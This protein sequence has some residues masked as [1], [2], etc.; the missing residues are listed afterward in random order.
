MRVKINIIK[1]L[2]M[3]RAQLFCVF[4]IIVSSLIGC[5]GDDFVDDEIDPVI[6]ISNPIAQIE[7]GTTHQFEYNYFNNIGQKENITDAVW[8]SSDETKLSIDPSGLASAIEEG[9]CMIKIER[10]GTSGL[11]MD[12]IEVEVI[13]M[14]VDDPDETKSGTIQT[15]SSYVLT[16]D[17]T[18]IKEEDNLK[19]SFADNYEA[20]T[21][22]PG[23]YVYLSNNPSTIAGAF[24]IGAVTVFSGIHDY[25]VPNVGIND[26]QYLL[27]FCKPFNVKVGDGKIN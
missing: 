12:A 21:A 24:E 7:L 6:K 1:K 20:S 13:D 4:V 22:L 26:F 23:L 9:F 25:T 27:Y 19:I 11:V 17:F 18:I 2:S 10:N 8:T 14:P 3:K 5:I 15:T 16:G